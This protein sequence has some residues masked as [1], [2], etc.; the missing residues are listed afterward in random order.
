MTEILYAG[1]RFVTRVHDEILTW[2]DGIEKSFTDKE[3]HFLVIGFCGLLLYIIIHA[4]FKW[5]SRYG[6]WAISFISTLA[7]MVIITFAIEIGQRWTGTG[8]MEFA[9][10]MFGMWGFLLFTIGYLAIKWVIRKLFRRNK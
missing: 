2:N 7:M 8:Q 6:I 5:L 1:V 10:I 4:L 9:D 3:L